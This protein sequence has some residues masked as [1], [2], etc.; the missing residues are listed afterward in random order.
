MVLKITD[1]ELKQLK[2]IHKEKIYHDFP[3]I[4]DILKKQERELSKLKKLVSGQQVQITK[5]LVAVSDIRGGSGNG[6][7][8]P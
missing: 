5:L 6:Q 1:R 4:A 3:E 8:V 7:N 2:K